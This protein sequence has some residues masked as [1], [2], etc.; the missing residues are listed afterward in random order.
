MRQEQA[1][2]KALLSLAFVSICKLAI[3]QSDTYF[4][5]PPLLEWQGGQHIIDLQISTSVP[6]SQ[7]WVYNSDTSYSQNIT[8]TQGNLSIITLSAI[9]GSIQSTYG[10]RN[11]S[12]VNQKRTKDA[13]FV[14]A[15]QPV[16]VTQRVRQQ[17]N[18]EII[19]GK[20]MN[21]IGKEFYVASQTEIHSTV[22]GNF[23]NYHGLHYVSI[24]ALEDNT[25][26]HIKASAGNT[27]TNGSD[28]AVFQLDQGESWVSTM[29]DNKVLLGTKVTSDKP[30][31]VTAGGNHLKTSSTN[32]A[33]AGI[34]QVTP[35]EHLGIKHVVLRGR[36]NHPQDYFMYV[37]TQNGTN[38][39]VDGTNILSNGNAGAAGTY[40]MNGNP[41]TPGK[42]FVVESNLPI[43]V[44]QV[45]SG[46]TSGEPEQGMAQ[47]PHLDCTG[48]TNVTYNRA[49][50]LATS[51]LITIPSNAV[52][53]LNYN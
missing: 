37:A 26:I 44:F 28:S 19:T 13:L 46:V 27:F 30:I 3:A 35:T 23:T 4:A 2:F 36:A 33:D 49:S 7:V 1:I 42:P 24:V 8:V 11:L 53:N 38:I 45:T 17:F 50:G 43:Y 25:E 16:T 6:S 47:L 22:T 15:S 29:Q 5:F 12:W 9:Q 39:S 41:A 31:A 48:S 18:Q 20:G 14:E 32:N 21:G 40:V 10:A 34:D 52:S 51:A